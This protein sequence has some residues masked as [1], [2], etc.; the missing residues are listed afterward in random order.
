MGLLYDEQGNRFTPSH[1]T[2]KG[3]RYRYYV[4]QAVI[5]KPWKKHRGPVR[6][7]ASE[8]EELVLSQLTL[9]AA[10][11]AADDGHPCRVGRIAGRSACCDRSISR[12]EHSHL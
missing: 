10:V 3:R 9:L 11:T 1:A 6:I 12:V 8:I 5:K 4:S 2:K 7:P